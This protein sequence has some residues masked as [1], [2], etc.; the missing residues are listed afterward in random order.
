MDV[1]L[2]DGE[3]VDVF[4]GLKVEM[5]RLAEGGSERWICVYVWN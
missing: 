5:E 1:F 2:C 3:C 4:K